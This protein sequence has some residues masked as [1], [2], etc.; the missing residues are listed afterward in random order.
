MNPHLLE[1]IN[2]TRMTLFKQIETDFYQEKII[3]LRLVL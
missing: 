1:N 2:R 3:P